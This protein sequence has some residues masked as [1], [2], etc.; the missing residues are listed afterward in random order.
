MGECDR[1][2]RVLPLKF[3]IF[4]ISPC[5]KLNIRSAQNNKKICQAYGGFATSR[6]PGALPLDPVGGLPSPRPPTSAHTTLATASGS[7][8]AAV[9][10]TP[11]KKAGHRRIIQ[12]PLNETDG[13]LPVFCRAY[14]TQLSYSEEFEDTPCARAESRYAKSRKG[15]NE[16]VV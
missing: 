11:A 6:P 13:C 9:E 1:G 12:H 8:S 4:I 3:I 15:E 5:I 16:A 10:L 14:Y 2:D 7:A